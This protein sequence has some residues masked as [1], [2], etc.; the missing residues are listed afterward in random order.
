MSEVDGHVENTI[1]GGLFIHA[2]VQ[3]RDVTVHL[4]T[5]ITPALSGLPAAFCHFH[6]P[7]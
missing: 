1:I 5:Q 3:G 4:P 6:R 7:R 2:V